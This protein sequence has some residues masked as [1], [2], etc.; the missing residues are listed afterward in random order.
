MIK[1]FLLI[2]LGG[3]IGSMIRYFFS[4]T[5]IQ[6]SWPWPTFLVNVIGSFIIGMIIAISLK[7][8]SFATNWKLFLATGI[9]GG[10]TTFSAFSVENLQL[11]QNGKYF[12]CASYII[13]SIV[14][15]IFAAWLGYKLIINN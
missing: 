9:C 12:L 5:F 6:R 13:A 11:L 15:G 3:A 4:L 7:N 10:F 14:L 1:K 8:E 2:G